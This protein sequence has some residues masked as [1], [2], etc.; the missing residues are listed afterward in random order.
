MDE[1]EAS[2]KRLVKS[3]YISGGYTESAKRKIDKFPYLR[4]AYKDWAGFWKENGVPVEFEKW[5]KQTV[6]QVSEFKIR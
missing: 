4:E 1:I 2:Q 3:F 5:N 6:E